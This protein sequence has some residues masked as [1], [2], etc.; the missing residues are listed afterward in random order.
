MHCSGWTQL[1]LKNFL[2]KFI[3]FSSIQSQYY[4]AI[5]RSLPNY[6]SLMCLRNNADEDCFFYCYTAAYDLYS[7]K[8][9]FE[10]NF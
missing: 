2:V 9:R 6:Q 7:N 3:S 8:L 1:E 5:A 10:T 4:I